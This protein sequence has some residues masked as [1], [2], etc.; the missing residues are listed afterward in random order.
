MSASLS[1]AFITPLVQFVTSKVIESG[2]SGD[3]AKQY[4]RAQELILVNAA[5]TAI[6]Q[7]DASGPALLAAAL[8]NQTALSPGA[9]I[10]LQSLLAVVGDQLTLLNKVAG[11]TLLGGSTEMIVTAILAAGTA[12]AKAYPAPTT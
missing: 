5:L 7:G 4:A 12:V 2:T 10:A 6:D 9:A 1:L 3:K 8:S 11:G